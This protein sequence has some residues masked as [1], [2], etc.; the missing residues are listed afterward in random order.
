MGQAVSQGRDE[1]EGS[2]AT[3]SCAKSKGTTKPF[4]RQDK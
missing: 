1:G 4:S 3:A 2:E